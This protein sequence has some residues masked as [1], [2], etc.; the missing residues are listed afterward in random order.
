MLCNTII[1]HY[2]D[3]SNLKRKKRNL[4]NFAHNVVFYSIMLYYV[5]MKEIT[6]TATTTTLSV[7]DIDSSAISSFR[8]MGNHH[9]GTLEVTF[10]S[11]SVY[12]YHGVPY[13][14]VLTMAMWVNGGESLGWYFAKH[15][16]QAYPYDLIG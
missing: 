16:R 3:K 6:K 13:I 11:G 15:V 9:T 4:K 2:R 10:Q 7:T 12:R 14:T 1:A 8:Y 5:C